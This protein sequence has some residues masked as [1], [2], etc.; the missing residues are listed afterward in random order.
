MLGT[1]Q[2][3]KKLFYWSKLKENVHEHVRN[4]EI[5]QMSKAEHVKASGLL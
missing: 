2:R 4:C 5:C 3:M 1:Y